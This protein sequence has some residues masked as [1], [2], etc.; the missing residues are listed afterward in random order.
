MT[1]YSL[2]RKQLEHPQ[3][4]GELSVYFSHNNT[5]CLIRQ[6]LP[7][8]LTLQQHRGVSMALLEGCDSFDN[9]AIQLEKEIKNRFLAIDQL[10][11]SFDYPI[12]VSQW[13][14][15]NNEYDAL[16]SHWR[17]DTPIASFEFHSHFI[18]LLIKLIQQLSEPIVSYISKYSLNEHKKDIILLAGITFQD[19]PRQIEVMA[20]IRGLV[21]F[22]T[23]SGYSDNTIRMR[24]KYLLQNVQQLKE[25]IISTLNQLSPQTLHTTPTLFESILHE[26][27]ISL[28][29]QLINK[30]FL[31]KENITAE[32]HHVFD[33]VTN[34]IDLYSAIL[35]QCLS[36]IQHRT[37][38][39]FALI[40]KKS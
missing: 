31:T 28:L 27:K 12:P 3:D 20:K 29:S 5:L 4:P 9:R 32:S 7:F 33:T 38:R 10:N 13:Q 2:N 40:Q 25:E 22:S 19:T 21:T 26:H 15:V 24:V 18:E 17:E 36:L 39:I 14:A 1:S 35:D 16:M 6:L 11:Q 37:D 34:I 8:L 23:V 30:E